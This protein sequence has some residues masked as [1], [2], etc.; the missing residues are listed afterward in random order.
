M[1]GYQVREQVAG[2]DNIAAAAYACMPPPRNESKA[3]GSCPV[4]VYVYNAKVIDMEPAETVRF[5]LDL[6]FRVYIDRSLPLIGTPDELGAG[7][8]VTLI[9]TAE[10]DG[11]IHARVYDSKRDGWP[12]HL[13]R[14]RARLV[15]VI[16]GDT[17]DARVW[18]YP[19]LAIEER[20]RLGRI[21]TPEIFGIRRD[22]PAYIRGITARDY[23][24]ARFG[25]HDGWMVMHTS[26]RG[27]WRR[28]L[29]EVFVGDS[30]TRLNDELLREHLAVVWLRA[31][32]RDPAKGK[33]LDLSPELR[34]RIQANADRLG[35]PPTELVE[36]ALAVYLE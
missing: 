20:F 32:R 1:P 26:R 18:I 4:H 19:D 8:E 24:V 10:E 30:T 35:L 15:R 17:F 31:P 7:D 23:V 16:D 2:A 5:R 12:S 22:D 11:R 28:W 21:S 3:E 27:K 29:A 9:V 34:D 13:W 6:G 25:E 14:Y 33:L 36:R